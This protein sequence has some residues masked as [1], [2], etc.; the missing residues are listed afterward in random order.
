MK[1]LSVII[2]NWNSEKFIAEMLSSIIAQTFTDWTL[3]VIDDGSTDS[4]KQIIDEFS[5]K[6]SRIVSLERTRL[7]KGAQTCRN[8]GMELSKNYEYVI[9]FD[10]DDIVAPY[11]F[12]QRVAFMDSHKELDFSIFPAKKF[13]AKIWDNCDRVYGVPCFEDTIKAF[14]HKALPMVGW[15]N[16]YRCSSI[17]EK[18]LY[19]DE[20][21]LSMQDSDFNIQAILKGCKY[22][23]VRHA[24]PDYFYRYVCASVSS[25]K[26]QRKQTHLPGH[27]YLLDKVV[28]S[29]TENQ[30]K[31][32]R[33]DIDNY[34]LEF[35]HISIDKKYK[36]DFCQSDWLRGRNWFLLR[37]KIL[38]KTHPKA[39]ILLFPKLG[40][41]HNQMLRK[42]HNCMREN[43]HE[44]LLKY[45]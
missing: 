14:L 11:C 1:K 32:Y 42:W 12:Q 34:Y 45:K 30:Q 39:R 38:A 10:S 28:K 7:P 6:D 19:W 21:L 36:N 15:T 22:D 3:F 40:F 2:P 37:M 8:I 20:N 23:F 13:Y 33:D 5:K 35:S 17:Q 44:F 9:F 16:I 43:A 24:K 29:L 26:S 31:Y 4:S 27:I 25:M 41:E 18:N